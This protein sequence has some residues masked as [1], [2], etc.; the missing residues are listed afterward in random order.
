ML[1]AFRCQ[2]DAASLIVDA[3]AQYRFARKLFEGRFY[4]A[5]IFEFQRF[6][7]FFP[8]DPREPEALSYVGRAYY[9]LEEYGDAI[10]RLQDL[11]DRFEGHPDALRAFF[12]LADCYID[13]NQ[14]RQAMVT[15][16]NLIALTSDPEL[17]DNAHYKLGW[18]IVQM[19]QWQ[20]AISAFGKLSP[21][22]KQQNSIEALITELNTEKRIPQKNPAL[23][24][25][26]SILPGAGQLYCE[27]YRDAL[28][29]FFV[30]TGLI[31]A[32][33]ESFNNQLYALGTTIS[34]FEFGFYAG[35]I[36]GAIASAHKY[37][38]MER[39]RYVQQ[40]EEK[41]RIGLLPTASQTGILLSFQYVF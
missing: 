1:T 30:N 4:E 16:Q 7:H 21:Q 37:N 22:F 6:I 34:I 19:G 11:I 17:L 27:R 33:I 28:S 23:A 36:N 3:E 40:L 39:Q 26:L 31:L 24:G 29:A 8:N 32:A 2:A 25:T 10:Q 15:L 12:Y 5:A 20:P 38:Q 9:H 41:F 13:L 35:N 18:L 14:P